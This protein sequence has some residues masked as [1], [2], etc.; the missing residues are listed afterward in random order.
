[1]KMSAHAAR[2]WRGFSRVLILAGEV[3]CIATFLGS[4]FLISY[5]SYKRPPAPEPER[6]WTVGIS[7]THPTRYGT[8]KEEEWVQRLFFWSF[9]SFGLIALGWGTRAYLLDD[10]SWIRPRKRP[11]W[12]HRWGPS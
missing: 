1:M 12:N 7:W 2:K 6:G 10:Y 5:Y 11:P 4:T 3:R 9:P 8:A